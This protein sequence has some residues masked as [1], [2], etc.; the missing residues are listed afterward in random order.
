MLEHFLCKS[1][2]TALLI[3]V[4]HS[5]RQSRLQVSFASVSRK[6]TL[7]IRQMLNPTAEIVRVRN[8]SV[9]WR[10]TAKYTRRICWVVL[11]VSLSLS[12][13]VVFSPPAIVVPLIHSGFDQRLQ[14]PLEKGLD[15][16]WEGAMKNF[17]FQL[18]TFLDEKKRIKNNQPN[19]QTLENKT[20]HHSSNLPAHLES[21][22]QPLGIRTNANLPLLGMGFLSSCRVLV[23]SW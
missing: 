13:A 22:S 2:L 21:C 8:G 5:C 23:R 9:F 4:T 6:V 12:A 18:S 20:N 19:K 1:S 15:C 11:Q 3:L 16:N 14:H 7:W 17:Y 10:K